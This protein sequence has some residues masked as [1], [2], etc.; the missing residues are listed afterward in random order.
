MQIISPVCPLERP[1]VLAAQ[2]ETASFLTSLFHPHLSSLICFL[3]LHLS[4][5]LI[6]PPVNSPTL[7]SP[8]TEPAPVPVRTLPRLAISGCLPGIILIPVLPALLLAMVPVPCPI[9]CIYIRLAAPI[10]LRYRP[11]RLFA[12]TLLFPTP[13]PRIVAAYFFELCR[14]YLFHFFFLHRPSIFV[15]LFGACFL[16]ISLALFTCA[17]SVGRVFVHCLFEKMPA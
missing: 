10:S 15:G 16:Y 17:I 5:F 8:T 11:Q 13:R 14:L 9:P 7:C 12:R 2:T 3:H 1:Q 4:W 6:S